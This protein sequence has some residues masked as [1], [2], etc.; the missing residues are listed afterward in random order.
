MDEIFKI[1]NQLKANGQT[2]TTALIKAR[3]SQPQPIPTIIAA[4][5]RW[6]SNPEQFQSVGQNTETPETTTEA[7]ELSTEQRIQQLENEVGQLRQQVAL[8]ARRLSLLEMS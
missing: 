5:Q 3:L 1:A 2:P 4:L 8:L 6:K 7:G